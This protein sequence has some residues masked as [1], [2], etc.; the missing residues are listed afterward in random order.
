MV[1]FVGG[2]E[3]VDYCGGDYFGEVMDGVELG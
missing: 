2:V 3:G 1:V